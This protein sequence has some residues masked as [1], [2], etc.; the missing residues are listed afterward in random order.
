MRILVCNDDGIAAPGLGL[1]AAAARTLDPDVW[2]VAPARKWTAASHRVSFDCDLVLEQ[3]DDRSYVCSGTPVDCVVAAMTVLGGGGLKPDLVLAGINDKRNVGEDIA[4]S[5]TIA[6]ARE[7]TFW[8]VP[9][10][11]LSRDAW[12]DDPMSDLA[13]IAALLR[14]LWQ[15]KAQWSAPG[16]WL[17]LNLPRVLPAPFA[18]A[19]LAHDKIASASDIVSDDGGRIIYRL[20]RGRAGVVQPGDENDVLASGKIVVVRYRWDA[21]APLDGAVLPDWNAVSIR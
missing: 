17:G 3:R 10:I 18:Q 13:P 12:P 7:A 6:I 5:G 2:T 15:R 20:R 1:L 14:F 16:T 21:I 4:Y 9:A 11:S 19:S 8:G